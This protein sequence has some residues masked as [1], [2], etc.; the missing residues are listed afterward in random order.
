V[1]QYGAGLGPRYEH[2]VITTNG[3]RRGEADAAKPAYAGGGRWRGAS[4]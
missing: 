4:L 3:D 1:P 2:S